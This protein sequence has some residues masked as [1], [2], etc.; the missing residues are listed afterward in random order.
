M[1]PYT[2]EQQ[3]G[4]ALK[5]QVSASK[6]K[7]KL[8]ELFSKFIRQ[9]GADENGMNRCFT[10]GKVAHWKLLQCGHYVSR[11][12]LATRWDEVNCQVQCPGCN[13]FKEGNKPNFTVNLESKYGKGTVERLVIKG[14]NTWRPT[15][16]E[17]ELLIKHYSKLIN[18]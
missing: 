6:L 13:L 11:T 18:A 12:K 10:C 8:D 14:N 9:R 7:K 3:L 5:K 16:F 15:A 17:L 1:R 2:K 4:N